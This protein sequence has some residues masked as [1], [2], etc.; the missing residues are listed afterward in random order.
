M[1]RF[2]QIFCALFLL[3]CISGCKSDKRDIIVYD[4]KP[5]N[6]KVDDIEVVK[7][8]KASKIYHTDSTFEYEYRTGE[9]G[10]YQYHYDVTGKNSKGEKVS[11]EVDMEGKYGVGK[12]NGNTKI[13]AEWM[14]K[15]KIEGKDEKG[16]YYELV[17]E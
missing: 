2:P 1:K 17:V 16:N 15:G 10:S 11:G 7:N 8:P 13:E 6:K 3:S 9:S 12:L 14:E 5:F 4:V